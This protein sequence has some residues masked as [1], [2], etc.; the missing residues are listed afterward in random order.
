[1]PLDFGMYTRL[2]G[3]ARQGWKVINWSTNRPRAAGV[4]TTTLSTPGVY[5]PAFTCVTLLAD[6]RM[7]E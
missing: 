5:L 4:F 1:M 6:M 7:L 2:T 3:R